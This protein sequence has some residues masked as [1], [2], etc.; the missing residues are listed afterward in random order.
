MFSCIWTIREYPCHVSSQN[1]MNNPVF[2]G[3][4][5]M[6]FF[7]RKSALEREWDELIKREEKYLSKRDDKKQ[8]TLDRLL[9]EKVP[10]KLQSTL[11]VAFL[12]AFALVFE[13][14]TGI[15]EKTYNADERKKNFSIDNY[16]DE[17]KQSRRTL[18]KFTRKA[19]AAGTVNM[20]VSGAAGIGMGA[21][22]VGI[23]DIPFFTAMLLRNVY[24]I[25]ISYGY[26]YRSAGEQH[27]ILM[28]IE[29]AVSFG[30]D[31]RRIDED[32]NTYIDRKVLPTAE[33]CEAQLKRTASALSNELLYMKFLQGIPIIGAVGG[34][35][36]VVYMKKIS[37]YAKL[38]YNR[39]LLLRKKKSK[40]DREKRKKFL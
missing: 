6:L 32:I 19:N 30:E 7:N 34:A 35:Y 40:E 27:F 33:E 24:Q 13:K 10:D 16:T 25:A 8:S 36:D 15:I 26:G 29:G 22:G 9:E 37:E 31:A 23:P 38:K 21:A 3:G 5:P 12:K 20:L 39:R 2:G 14:G 4:D 28:V 17:M 18:K 1:T 11:D